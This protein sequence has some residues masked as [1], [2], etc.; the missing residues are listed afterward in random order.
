M[1]G[2]GRRRGWCLNLDAYSSDKKQ[3]LRMFGLLSIPPESPLLINL[4]DISWK[5]VAKSSWLPY[6]KSDADTP[7]L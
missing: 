4:L 2:V 6:K 3:T 5:L 7:L 1:M